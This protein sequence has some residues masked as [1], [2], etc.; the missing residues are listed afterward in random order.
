MMP[1]A[2]SSAS[3][4]LTRVLSCNK[5]N[6][7]LS[8]RSSSS[9]SELADEKPEP[10]IS[11]GIGIGG[12]GRSYEYESTTGCVEVAGQKAFSKDRASNKRFPGTPEAGTSNLEVFLRMLRGRVGTGLLEKRQKSVTSGP[13][14]RLEE[15]GPKDVVMGAAEVKRATKFLKGLILQ[16]DCEAV[17]LACCLDSAAARARRGFPGA[18]L[19]FPSS[20]SLCIAARPDCVLKD[21]VKAVIG[22][23]HSLWLLG[24]PIFPFQRAINHPRYMMYKDSYP[25]KEVTDR[26]ATRGRT[27]QLDKQRAPVIVELCSCRVRRM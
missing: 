26:L 19:G 2:E 8:S 23:V 10:V 13:S 3:G 12:K 27:M 21:G 7:R 17:E 5:D 1:L 11:E 18:N 15:A 14:A 20:G 25:L 4:T 9:S 24:R 22:M 6:G 16:V